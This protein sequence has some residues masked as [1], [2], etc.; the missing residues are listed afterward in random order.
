MVK[1]ISQETF[2]AAVKENVEEFGMGLDEARKD[3][4]QQFQAQVS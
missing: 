1:V 3:A 4:V 2:D